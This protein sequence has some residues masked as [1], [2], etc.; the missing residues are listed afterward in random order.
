MSKGALDVNVN[1]SR[2]T[3]SWRKDNFSVTIEVP[4]EPIIKLMTPKSEQ[5]ALVDLNVESTNN[6]PG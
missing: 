5:L 1:E 6:S 4:M 3:I 2:A